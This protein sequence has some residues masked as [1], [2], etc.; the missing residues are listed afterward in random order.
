MRK[1]NVGLVMSAKII[2]ILCGCLMS[3]AGV[4]LFFLIGLEAVLAQ[5][6]FLGILLGL[7]GAAK[8]FG[9]FSNDLYRL[10][11]QYDLAMGSFCAVLSLIA[12]FMPES[13]YSTFPLLITLYVLFDALLK[14]QMAFDAKGFGMKSWVLI[15]ITAA[16][17]C[18]AVLFAAASL[19]AELFR[20]LSAVGL[21]LLLDGIETTWITAHTVRIRGKK[22]NL[23]ERF[24]LD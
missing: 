6:I 18:V 3:V 10:A 23:D 16:I 15:L 7:C 2:N 14:L 20:P 21:A 1:Q 12:I 11:F 13:M 9:Y 17:L 19:L 4:L 24:E 8:I 5:R 22:K